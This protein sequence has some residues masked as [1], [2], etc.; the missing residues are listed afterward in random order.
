MLSRL[1]ITRYCNLRSC[2]LF[3]F[4]IFLFVSEHHLNFLN[5]RDPWKLVDQEETG[6]KKQFD[7]FFCFLFPVS[8]HPAWSRRP[9][10][11]AWVTRAYHLMWYHCWPSCSTFSRQTNEKTIWILDITLS[12]SLFSTGQKIF[13]R[14]NFCALHFFSFFAFCEN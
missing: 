3:I 7:T 13:A 1:S 11:Y 6:K 5:D 2:V 4:F 9:E 10:N 14:V 12:S 8:D